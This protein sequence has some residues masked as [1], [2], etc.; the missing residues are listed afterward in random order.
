MFWVPKISGSCVTC[1]LETVTLAAL[2]KAAGRKIGRHSANDQ[3]MQ[4]ALG[5]AL[6]I[7]PN[8]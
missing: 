6:G 7:Y 4:H 8:E 1:I 5:G 3:W 2:N